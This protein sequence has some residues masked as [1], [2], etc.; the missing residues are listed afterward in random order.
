MTRK[1]F[2]SVSKRD[3]KLMLSYFISQIPL[4]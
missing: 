1:S 2:D 3:T 4:L